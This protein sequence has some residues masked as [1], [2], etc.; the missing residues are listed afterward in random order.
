MRTLLLVAVAVGAS[1]A[2]ANE[3][4]DTLAAQF[5]L[6]ASATTGT[7]ALIVEFNESITGIANPL[8]QALLRFGEQKLAVLANDG[9][10]VVGTVNNGRVKLNYLPWEEFVR[11]N[12]QSKE[13]G[14]ANI[15]IHGE[16]E[17]LN[18]TFI[19][20]ALAPRNRRNASM[21]THPANG[22]VSNTTSSGSTTSC[23]TNYQLT[24]RSVCTVNSQ[25]FAV[26]CRSDYY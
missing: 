17:F 21:A 18:G 25:T 12:M 9:M 2:I 24:Y 11:N 15:E 23:Y 20:Y 14:L 16:G 1:S 6:V 8:R 4:I 26:S 3:V 19:A 7:G 5:P 13:F 22:C 10:S